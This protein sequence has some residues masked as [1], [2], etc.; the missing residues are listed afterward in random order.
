ML[1]GSTCG[2]EEVFALTLVIPSLLYEHSYTGIVFFKAL[3]YRL[4]SS[5]HIERN[6]YLYFME[7]VQVNFNMATIGKDV[8]AFVRSRAARLG[9]F[10]V[11][12]ENDK[13][14]KEDPRTG[15]KTILQSSER[16]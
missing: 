1:K 2:T 3:I 15:Q 13:I 9:S 7:Q 10:I 8:E 14:I 16:K 11:Y 4:F 5:K 6:V 12:E